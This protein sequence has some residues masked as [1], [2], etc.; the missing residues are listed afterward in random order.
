MAGIGGPKKANHKIGRGAKLYVITLSII[1]TF[2]SLQALNS[3]PKDCDL[4][5]QIWP[6]WINTD[7]YV[8]IFPEHKQSINEGAK[9]MLHIN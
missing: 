2:L 8:C 4:N 9:S 3:F 7:M 1:D 5:C 6:K